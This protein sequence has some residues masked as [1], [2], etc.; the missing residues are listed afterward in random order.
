[1]QPIAIEAAAVGSHLAAVFIGNLRDDIDGTCKSI[2]AVYAST[3]AFEYFDTLDGVE[4]H[5]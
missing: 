4:A 3:G 5:R 1:M 2:L